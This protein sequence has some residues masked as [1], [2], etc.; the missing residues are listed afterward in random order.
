[1]PTPKLVLISGKKNNGKDLLGK[2]IGEGLEAMGF[3]PVF[4]S[5]AD[6]VKD[7]ACV[8]LGCTREK[9]EDLKNANIKVRELLQVIGTECGRT[10]SEG[11][12][13]DRLNERLNHVFTDPKAIAIVTDCRFRNEAD[14]RFDSVTRAETLL[15]RV[16]RETHKSTG[17]HKSEIDLDQY[18]SWDCIIANNGTKEDLRSSADAIVGEFWNDCP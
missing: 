6:P 7:A 1:M 17:Y 18:E 15:L 16:D 14:A 9:L 8:I 4:L 13:V 12:W 3:R 2:Y 10:Y 5:F 11:I